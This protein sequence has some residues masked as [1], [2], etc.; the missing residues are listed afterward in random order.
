MALDWLRRNRERDKLVP[1]RALLGPPTP[2]TGR[3]KALAIPLRRCLWTAGSTRRSWRSTRRRWA[4]TASTSWGCTPTKSPRA[5]PG[6]RES[7]QDMAGAAAGHGRVRHGH[8]LRGLPGG[9]AVRLAERTGPLPR[10][11]PFSSPRTTGRTWASWPSTRSTG[12]RNYP[13]CHIP[14]IMKWPGC[15]AGSVDSGLHYSLDL[16]PH[17]GP[18]AGGWSPGRS[19]DGQSFAPGCHRGEG[20]RAGVPGALPRWPTC[21]SARRGL[22]TGFTSAPSTTGTTSLTGRC[23]LT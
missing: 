9:A 14:F 20:R 11:R 18:A 10:T 16:L 3:R 23:S 1:A 17:H 22:G 12:R 19:G 4:P 8:S 5:T 15:K 2:P 13:T 21:A 7:A 6:C